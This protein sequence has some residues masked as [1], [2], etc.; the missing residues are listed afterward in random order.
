MKMAEYEKE[1]YWLR[2]QEFITELKTA[3]Y[4]CQ[5]FTLRIE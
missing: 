5:M 3:K 1:E 2:V 4:W